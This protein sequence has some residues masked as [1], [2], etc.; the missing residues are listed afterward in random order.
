MKQNLFFTALLFTMSTI[1]F[2]QNLVTFGVRGGL[3]M[4]NLSMNLPSNLW[5]ADNQKKSRTSFNLGV[6][7]QYS[8]NEKIALQAELFYSGE[9]ANFTDPGT[10]LPAHIKLSYLSLPI[11]FKYNIVKNFYAMAGPQFSYLLAA[12]S[13]YE[14]GNSYNVLSEH[15]KID[16][17]LVPVIGYDWKQF[18]INL[19]YH[20]GLSKLPNSHSYWSY[21]PYSDDKVKSNVFSVVVSYKVFGVKE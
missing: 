18:S 17:G 6:Y 13:I 11:F 7:G 16:V 9:G 20:I 10:E 5:P 3:N 4:A 19:R 14:N 8:L 21:S 12:H 1:T 15:N 2:S